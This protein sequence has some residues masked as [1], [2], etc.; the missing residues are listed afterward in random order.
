MLREA[1][2]RVKR[3]KERDNVNMKHQSVAS[4]KRIGDGGK[5]VII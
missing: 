1:G 4:N 5:R 3:Q 2:K